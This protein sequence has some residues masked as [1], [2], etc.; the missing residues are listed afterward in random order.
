MVIR[1]DQVA[2]GLQLIGAGAVSLVV[3]APSLLAAARKQDQ[4][5]NM[6][7]RDRARLI[8]R[9]GLSGVSYLAL[10]GA[11]I[12][13]LATLISA[14]GLVL[15]VAIVTLLLISLRNTWDLLVTV[16]EVSLGSDKDEG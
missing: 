1:E 12:L 10:M 16:G 7:R 11:G 14:S 5:F 4:G 6:R 9:F 2:A 13:L 8:L 15:V 3:T